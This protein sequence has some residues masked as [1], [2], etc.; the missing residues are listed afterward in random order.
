MCVR[1]RERVRERVSAGLS[2]QIS[3]LYIIY[4]HTDKRADRETWTDRD[5]DRVGG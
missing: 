2:V 4:M 3:L 5:V 1:E